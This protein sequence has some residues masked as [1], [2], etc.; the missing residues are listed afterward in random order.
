MVD[1]MIGLFVASVIATAFLGSVVY[2]VQYSIEHNRKLQAEFLAVELLE[3]ARAMENSDWDALMDCGDECYFK[4]G[5]LNWE[6]VNDE[7]VEEVGAF[8]RF[9]S[10]DDVYRN[11]D[12][13][14][15]ASSPDDPD[16]FT[17]KATATVSWWS[18]GT[19]SD[20]TL[21]IYVYKFF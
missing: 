5:T 11:E 7:G 12:N 8:K 1:V 3:I 18:R 20:L 10:I 15:V 4:P 21:E 17:K 14:I 16:E 19:S 9:L 2:A 13:V 6:V